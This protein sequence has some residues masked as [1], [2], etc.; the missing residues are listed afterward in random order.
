MLVLVSLTLQLCLLH[1][2]SRR[3]YSVK[4]WLR[5]FLWL[6][7]LG[8][9]SV[10]TVALGVI[11][12]NQ[13]NCNDSQSQNEFIAF[14]APFL[15]LHLGGQDTI[16]A[17]AVQDNELWLRHLLG[18]VVQS[19]VA[20][21]IFLVSWKASWLSFLTIPMFLAGFIKYA[22]RTWVL[23]SANNA[24]CN[25]G[26]AI[27]GTSNIFTSEDPSMYSWDEHLVVPRDESNTGAEIR[28]AFI[29]FKAFRD[30]FLN[31][32]PYIF[33]ISHSGYY[34]NFH[35][36]ETAWKTI[37]DELGYAYDVYYTK[38]PLFFTASGFLFRLFSFTSIIFVFVLFHAK[39]RHKHLQIDLIITYLLLVGAV[40]IEIYAV[41]LLCASDWPLCVSD[42]EM[43]SFQLESRPRDRDKCLVKHIAHIRNGCAKLTS[44]QR[45]SNS[46]GQLNLLGLC[47]K[48]D[49]SLQDGHGTPKLFANLREWAFNHMLPR[50]NRELEVLF[51]RTNKQVSAELK[52][53]VFNTFWE[54]LRS[55]SNG[56]SE[57][58]DKYITNGTV[59]VETHRSIIIWHIA[60]DLCFYNDI[61]TNE[62]N[63]SLKV[64]SK[65]VSDYM[66][67]ILAMCPLAFSTGNAK[68][69]FKK[70]CIWVERYFHEREELSRLP[71][72]QVC[73]QMMSKY[74]AED[75]GER[76]NLAE[77]HLLPL[78][79]QL[80]IE[81]NQKDEKWEILSKF[82]VENL[83]YVATL[84]QGNYHA[85]LLRKG[86]EF[87][88]HVWLLIEQFNLKESFQKSRTRPK[89]EGAN[90]SPGSESGGR[91][92]GSVSESGNGQGSG[93][94][95]AAVSGANA[96]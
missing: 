27:S 25:W 2:G 14:W 20:I 52:D 6:S 73:E 15:L 59:N 1:F 96:S 46:M 56:F 95:S 63:L 80:A 85:Q 69:G 70:T 79:I 72:D 93:N 40:L 38:A 50:L 9:D 65:D 24:K 28:D 4:T 21:Y 81:L 30:L 68:L 7:Y 39:E 23:K 67:Y 86:G 57:E 16:T 92:T 62:P 89:E 8:A 10:A 44:K 35:N 83:A 31:Q 3:R 22:E 54:K 53:F 87:L 49:N 41:I 75:F 61:D 36:S 66:M 64:M 94:G 55:N 37:E 88:T 58:Y 91:A 77:V 82:W 51:Y 45:W 47:L 33:F 13:G 5:V 71:K 32:K 78:A 12:T 19:G 43:E 60:T 17:C 48:K 29:L 74:E 76:K 84:C 42:R 18:L 34:S 11:S 26:K 90:V